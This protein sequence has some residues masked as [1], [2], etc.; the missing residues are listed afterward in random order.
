MF[1]CNI[2]Y[3][4]LWIPGVYGVVW[5][6]RPVR[7]RLLRRNLAVTGSKQKSTGCYVAEIG[8][9]FFFCHSGGLHRN[10]DSRNP[11]NKAA[12]QTVVIYFVSFIMLSILEF[13]TGS[14]VNW[15]HIGIVDAEI[16]AVHVFDMVER[17]N[18]VRTG[19]DAAL[20]QLDF[21]LS[22]FS[23]GRNIHSGY[24]VSGIHHLPAIV[25]C[26]GSYWHCSA[27]TNGVHWYIFCFFR[28]ADL[29]VQIPIGYVGI[30]A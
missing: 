28:P 12:I 11:E 29:I 10:P 18:I 5:L 4:L 15:E 16:L 23:A 21:R 22:S 9:H 3:T 17:E 24:A 20:F 2:L 14:E 6:R 27:L 30:I 7:R 25:Y 13:N 1:R 26:F 19:E 8:I